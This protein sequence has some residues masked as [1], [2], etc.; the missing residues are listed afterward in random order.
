M[1]NETY[2]PAEVKALL[3]TLA[4]LDRHDEDSLR[5]GYVVLYGTINGIH[6]PWTISQRLSMDKREVERWCQNLE[7]SGIWKNGVTYVETPLSKGTYEAIF[8]FWLNVMVALG[9]IVS[10]QIPKSEA[11]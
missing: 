4:S 11:R 1:N 7:K 2:T 5:A 10:I 9:D 8:E 3:N 6:T